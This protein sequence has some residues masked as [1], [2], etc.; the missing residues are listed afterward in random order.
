M[1]WLHL[2]KRSVVTTQDGTVDE[3]VRSRV[4]EMHVEAEMEM[5]LLNVNARK[6]QDEDEEGDGL[7][8]KNDSVRLTPGYPADHFLSH[9]D[10]TFEF[11]WEYETCSHVNDC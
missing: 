10:N 7:N 8:E 4:I 9:H 3:L 1:E 6:E 2:D 5:R 11:D